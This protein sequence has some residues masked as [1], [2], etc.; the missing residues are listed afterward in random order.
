MATEPTGGWDDDEYYTG[1]ILAETFERTNY[2][3]VLYLQSIHKLYPDICIPK[4]DMDLLYDRAEQVYNDIIINLSAKDIQKKYQ[5]LFPDVLLKYPKQ[6]NLL[7]IL[8]SLLQTTGGFLYVDMDQSIDKIEQIGNINLVLEQIRKCDKRF[9]LIILGLHKAN[10]GGHANLLL[11]DK[12]KKIVERFEPHGV[13]D[14]TLFDK[15][16]LDKVLGDIFITLEKYQEYVIPPPIA[17]N[18]ECIGIQAVETYFPEQFKGFCLTWS[19]LYGIL[20][21]ENPD[22]S[23]MELNEIALKLISEKAKCTE[24]FSRLKIRQSKLK[25]LFGK[26]N[27]EEN[28]AKFKENIKMLTV[29]IKT[30]ISERNVE[31]EKEL[32]KL[33]KRFK[34]KFVLKGRNLI[35]DS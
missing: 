31:M 18:S 19:L 8:D 13:D 28:V 30:F 16:S 26:A 35:D 11:I 23:S 14:P 29:F 6:I 9:F 10:L 21:I 3:S 2:G 12:Q 17:E 34:V 15:S 22:L 4:I 25:C 33:N 7:Q 20:R 5:F 24:T 27:F 32:D 1:L